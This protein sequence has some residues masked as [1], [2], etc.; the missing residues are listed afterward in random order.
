M[1]NPFLKYTLA[2]LVTSLVVEHCGAGHAVGDRPVLAL[3]RFRLVGGRAVTLER[4]ARTPGLSH[5]APFFHS[6]N[7]AETRLLL[8]P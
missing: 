7:V 6:T 2:Q 3:T 8:G 4:L 5:L 1:K